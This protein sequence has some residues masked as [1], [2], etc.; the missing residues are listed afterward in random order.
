[1]S[2]LGRNAASWSSGMILRL[3]RRGLGFDSP[4]SPLFILIESWVGVVEMHLICGRVAQP[5]A[6]RSHNPEVESSSLS[7]PIFSTFSTKPC[8][9]RAC[10][11]TAVAGIAQSVERQALNLM[12]AGSSPVAGYF[13]LLIWVPG[14]GRPQP[15]VLWQDGR[16]V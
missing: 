16:V 8:R 9:G 15:E 4:R 7:A 14:V 5:V 13:F 3:G 2:E 12:V 11:R 10:N 1:M 6:R